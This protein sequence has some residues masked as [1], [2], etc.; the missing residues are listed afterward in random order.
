MQ[1]CTSKKIVN[2]PIATGDAWSSSDGISCFSSAPAESERPMDGAGLG[3]AVPEIGVQLE[4]GAA[5]GI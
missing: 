1:K 3:D 5:S 2:L 4:E